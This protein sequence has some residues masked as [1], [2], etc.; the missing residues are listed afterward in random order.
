MIGSISVIDHASTQ[1]THRLGTT[2]ADVAVAGDHDHLAGHHD[3]GGPLDAVGQRFAAAVEVVELALGDRVVDVDRRHLQLAAL[4]HLV[5]P[6]D[7]RGRFFATG[8]ECRRAARGT[9]RGPS[10]SDRRRR[11]ESCSAARRRG[12]TASARCTNR[13]LRCVIALPGV[14]RACR[15]WR[16]LPR[17]DP[18]SRKCCSC[19]K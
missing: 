9:C 18:A 16:S 1:A 5:E 13:I 17:R 2:L 4:V 8:R 7:A 3:V 15:P 12:R 6:M 11:R 10:R 19:S 14:D